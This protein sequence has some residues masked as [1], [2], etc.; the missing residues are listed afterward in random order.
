MITAATESNKQKF[1]ELI[2]QDR[3][4]I[5]REIAAQLEVEHHEV[6]EMMEILGYRKICSRNLTLHV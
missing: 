4:R 6:Q 1:D 2:R 5:G 3:K